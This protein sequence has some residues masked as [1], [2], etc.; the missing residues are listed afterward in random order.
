[1]AS[2]NAYESGCM[3]EV[4]GETLRPGGFNLT[5]TAVQ[6][7]GLLPQSS[8]L[9]LG[10]GRGATV[11]YLHE[12]Y[13]ISAIG[14]DPSEKLI[15]YARRN[16]EYATF[17][18]GAGEALPFENDSF[19]CVFAECTL[20]LMDT[21]KAIEQVFRV[22]KDDGWFVISDVYAKNPT[23]AEELQSYSINSCM[24][25]MH[26]LDK[27]T[28]RLEQAGF[29]IAYSEDFSWYLK[30]LLVKIGFSYGSMCDF[31]SS[32][33]DKCINGDDFYRTIKQCKPGYFMLIVRK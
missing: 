11:N 25:G 28:R 26:D 33:S 20:S 32:A 24:R 29:T 7:C 2:N 6:F 3:Q 30:E 13:G 8:V 1:M 10:C 16:F 21:D 14:I 9:D 15:E 23:S 17:V 19:D 4:L 18:S 22:L 27:L 31:W 12:K 5:D